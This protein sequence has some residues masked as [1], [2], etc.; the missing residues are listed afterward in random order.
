MISKVG[1]SNRNYA[2]DYINLS[3]DKYNSVNVQILLNDNLMAVK[4]TPRYLNSPALRFALSRT[5]LKKS[6]EFSLILPRREIEIE[7][8]ARNDKK[9]NEPAGL[10]LHILANDLLFPAPSRTLFDSHS[11]SLSLSLSTLLRQVCQLTLC[12]F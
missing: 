1:K 8:G 7:K 3:E 11:L 10:H 6:L 5:L 4:G 9:V 12:C 2:K